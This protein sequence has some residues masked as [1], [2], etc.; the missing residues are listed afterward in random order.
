[1]YVGAAIAT[2]AVIGIVVLG[3][4][5]I[6]GGT[7]LTWVWLALSALALVVGMQLLNIASIY[8]HMPV[9]WMIALGAS[10][11]VVI[12]LFAMVGKSLAWDKA[13][14]AAAAGVLVLALVGNTMLLMVSP[15]GKLYDPFFEAR[16]RQIAN[17]AGFGVLLPQGYKLQLDYMPIDPIGRD[18][19]EGVSMR[20]EGFDIQ[21]RKADAELTT[22]DLEKM[23]AAGEDPLGF[24]MRITSAATYE[25]F[26]VNG[27]PAL[28]VEFSLDPKGNAP[29]GATPKGKQSVIRI[30][31]FS[32]D[33][34]DVRIKSEGVMEYQGGTGKN[35]RYDWV[36]PLELG[37]LVAVGE[38]L[39]PLE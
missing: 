20:Y 7:R 21:E 5:V 37:E 33:G 12:A 36:D 30:L 13:R 15:A 28:G 24:D 39:K 29:T 18:S 38:S 2:G 32:A 22:A 16:S 14:T 11:L 6:K 25:E 31:A 4:F 19:V 27:R 1:M 3:M 34:V 35:E 10:A 9:G 23:L 26:E 17:D 8:F